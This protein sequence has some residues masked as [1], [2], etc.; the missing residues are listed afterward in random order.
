MFAPDFSDRVA[1]VT[2]AGKGIGQ[3]TSIAFARLGAR[4]VLSGQSKEP[5]LETLALIENAGGR[6]V[7]VVGDMSQESAA[8]ETVATALREFGRLDCAVNNAGVSPSTAT[9]LI[10]RSRPG[11]G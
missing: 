7:I 3:A 10:A 8:Q 2:G 5:L 4:V 9:P 1:I 11:S 6:A